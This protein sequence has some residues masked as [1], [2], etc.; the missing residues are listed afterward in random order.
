MKLPCG[1]NMWTEA[2]TFYIIPC[3]LNCQNYKYAID[4]SKEQGNKIIEKRS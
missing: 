3:S 2:K 1:C 4:K